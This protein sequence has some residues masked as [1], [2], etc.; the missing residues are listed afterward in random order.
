MFISSAFAQEATN[1]VA[2]QPSLMQSLMPFILIFIVFYFLM[3]RPQK[4][5][6]DQE[7][8]FL[9]ALQ[10]GQEIYLK[11]GII[12]TIHGLTDKVVTLEVADGTRIKVLRS[13]IGGA[14]AKLFE[15]KD[16]KAGSGKPAAA[17]K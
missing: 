12:G 5:K 15:K 6:L 17:K 7:Q 16:E 13:S 3:I 8:N 2:Q 9:N 10:K 14:T 4:K 11:S 1:Q